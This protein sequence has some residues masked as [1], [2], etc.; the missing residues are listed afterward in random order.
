MSTWP[1]RLYGNAYLAYHL[2]GQPHFPFK[3]P[4]EIARARDRRVRQTVLHAYRSVPYYRELLPR[5]G[6]SPDDFRTADDL[7]RLPILEREDIQAN[8]RAFLSSAY[9]EDRC[10]AVRT[11]GSTGKSLP[12]LCDSA[13][14]LQST[15]Y[16]RR[17]QAILTRLLGRSYGYREVIFGSS[18]GITGSTERF[19][20]ANIAVPPGLRIVRRYHPVL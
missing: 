13:A 3:P 16:G 12:V 10:L 4:R 6:L 1:A 7:A 15:A 17:D 14:V 9:R 18:S 5:L 8:P 2:R 19:G 11:G 20:L